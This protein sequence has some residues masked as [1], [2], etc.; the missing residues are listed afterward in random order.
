MSSQQIMAMGLAIFLLLL[1][2]S[3]VIAARDG[4]K[5]GKK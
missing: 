4:K 2:I 3:T 1:G 5:G